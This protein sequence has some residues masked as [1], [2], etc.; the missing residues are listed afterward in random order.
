MSM[1]WSVWGELVEQQGV[2]DIVRRIEVGVGSAVDEAL[3]LQAAE[4]RVSPPGIRSQSNASASGSTRLASL[5]LTQRVFDS[6][7]WRHTCGSR[8]LRSRTSMSL[9]GGNGGDP[10]VPWSQADLLAGSR[11]RPGID[12]H[13]PET[14][15]PTAAVF[16]A[17]ALWSRSC[18][19]S[20]AEGRHG[21]G[22][23]CCS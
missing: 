13:Q 14:I 19:L 23:L 3:L 7:A 6:S 11:D 5:T 8:S 10:T 21:S 18:A 9:G 1:K 22:R 4:R 2:A 16:G 12:L 20:R 15:L 17:L